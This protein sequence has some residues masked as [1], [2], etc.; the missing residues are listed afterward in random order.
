MGWI[1][2][3]NMACVGMIGGVLISL[4]APSFG[5]EAGGSVVG[6]QGG[7]QAGDTGAGTQQLQEMDVGLT[8]LQAQV[9]TL[10]ARLEKLEKDKDGPLTIKGPLIVTNAQ[11]TQIFR[12]DP[13]GSGGQVTIIGGKSRAVITA[14]DAASVFLTDY[15]NTSTVTTES[16][17]HIS[18]QEGSKRF[19][20]GANRGDMT[21]TVDDGQS[22]IALVARPGRPFIDVDSGSKSVTVGAKGNSFGVGVLNGENATAALGDP[23]DGNPSLRIYEKGGGVALQAGFHKNGSPA[24]SVWDG[25]DALV[26]IEKADAGGS[27]GQVKVFDGG[28]QVVTLGT[29][30]SATGLRVKKDDD[31][32]FAGK[33]AEGP[34]FSLQQGAEKVFDVTVPG[35]NAQLS[36]GKESSAAWSMSSDPSDLELKGKVG[37]QEIYLELAATKGLLLQNGGS[38]QAF[39]GQYKDGKNGM[40][41]YDTGDTPVLFAGPSAGG[42][43]GFRVRE[44]GS[45]KDIATLGSKD[46]KEGELR[47]FDSSGETVRIGTTKA[48]GAIS[49]SKGGSPTI[50]LGSTEAK[51]IP[52]FRAYDGGEMGIAVGAVAGGKGLLAAFSGGHLSAGIEAGDGGNGTVYVMSNG[53]EAASI[54]STDIQGEGRVVVYGAGKKHVAFMGHGS[55]GGGNFTATDPGGTGV[56]SA[57]YIGGDGPGTA[58]VLQKGMKCLGVGLTGMEGFH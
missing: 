21:L 36:L 28:Q 14:A 30:D 41:I 46:G 50:T 17:P 38:T 1:K 8:A 29:V 52:A 12:V 3:I 9:A 23:G 40:G 31:V 19:F 25:D 27:G 48:S 13:E 58:C 56:F 51:E 10:T 32:L 33:G 42:Q 44:K 11:G 45:G 15:T 4:A 20:V 16:G 35:G 34:E 54:N 53:A 57:G 26:R 5:Q 37:E 39:I 7:F 24:F 18:L 43:P 55:G 6:E 2:A 47:I 22:N 49:L